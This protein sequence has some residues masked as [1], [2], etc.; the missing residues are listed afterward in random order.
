MLVSNLLFVPVFLGACSEDHPFFKIG[1][2]IP[3]S[4]EPWVELLFEGCFCLVHLC[5]DLGFD[6]RH[7]LWYGFELVFEVLLHLLYLFCQF[8]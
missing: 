5:A 1:Y 4:L 2:D 7:F 8:L 6:G 3:N